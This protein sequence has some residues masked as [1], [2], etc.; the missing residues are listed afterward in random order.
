MLQSPS[1]KHL[2]RSSAQLFGNLV[3]C[4]ILQQQ[5]SSLKLFRKLATHCCEQPRSPD[6]AMAHCMICK[7]FMSGTDTAAQYTARAAHAL[8][9]EQICAQTIASKGAQPGHGP[10]ADLKQTKGRPATWMVKQFSFSV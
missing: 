9:K 4:F 10:H 8:L 3:Y 5:R 1:K 2:W 6:A 7:Q